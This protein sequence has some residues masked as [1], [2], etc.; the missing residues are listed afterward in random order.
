MFTVACP[1]YVCVC[2]VMWSPG[3]DIFYETD[4]CTAVSP[5]YKW[6]KV[7]DRRL[8]ADVISK[9]KAWTIRQ[10]ICC[11]FSSW[12]DSNSY[13]HWFRYLA[14]LAKPR[15]IASHEKKKRIRLVLQDTILNYVSESLALG[16]MPTSAMLYVGLAI[17][18]IR[19][20][21]TCSSVYVQFNMNDPSSQFSIF[22][23]H[24]S[25]ATLLPSYYHCRE[26]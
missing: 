1:E 5:P 23:S 13:F 12:S 24:S 20:Q 19:H 17:E 4:D 26:G 10:S 22:P 9:P 18:W 3:V 14:C 21:R 11:L 7:P 25:E 6:G 2:R 15:G 8:G 16:Q